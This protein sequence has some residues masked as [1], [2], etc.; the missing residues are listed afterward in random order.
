ME[1][2]GSSTLQSPLVHEKRSPRDFPI[3][4]K[5]K[6]MWR[7]LLTLLR[8]QPITI[9]EAK[10]QSIGVRIH[11]EGPEEYRK[12]TDLL[13]SKSW[14]YHTYQLPGEK[15]LK[16]IFIEI[17]QGVTEKEII[18]DLQADGFHPISA[19]KMSRKQNGEKTLDSLGD[20]SALKGRKIYV[21]FGTYATSESGSS[22]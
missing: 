16:I 20:D 7:A 13:N 4:L 12:I 8:Q 22:P 5:L 18:A 21:R 1:Q 9:R 14:E 6:E 3:V 10:Y 17:P 19:S 2:D 15:T 11:P